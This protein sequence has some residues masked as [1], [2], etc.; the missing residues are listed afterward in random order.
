MSKTQ[1]DRQKLH[2]LFTVTENE[3]L[4]ELL[5]ASVALYVT[6]VTPTGNG[7]PEATS[8]MRLTILP[9]LSVTGGSDHVTMVG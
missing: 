5:A 7:V 1:T 9:E 8:L 2:P 3:Q 6:C 4:R